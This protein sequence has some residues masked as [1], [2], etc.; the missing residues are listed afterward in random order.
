MKKFFM[1]LL[2]LLVIAVIGAGVFLAT[3]DADQYRP[4]ILGLIEKAIQK[5]VRLEKITL[6]WK[7]GMALELQGFAILKSNQ[8]Q[9]KLVEVQ[10]AKAVLKLVPL[11][12]KRIQVAAIHL[13]HPVIRLVKNPDGTFEGWEPEPAPSGET[14]EKADSGPE[15]AALLS[16]LVNEIRVQDGELFFKDRS[17]K[18]SMELDLRKIDVMVSDVELNRPINFQVNAAVLSKEQNLEVKGK[19][20]LA[21]QTRSGTVSGLRVE[22]Q[23]A[24][25]DFQE[26]IRLSPDLKTSGIVFPLGGTLTAESDSLK[27]DNEK[28]INNGVKILLQRGKIHFETLRKPIENISLGAW[29]TNEMIEIQQFSA[30]VAAG[31]VEGQGAV[32]LADSKNPRTDFD[33]KAD[34]ISIEELTPDYSS[35]PQVRGLLSAAMRGKLSGQTAEEMLRT[36]TAD[37]SVKLDQ[38]V[39][40]RVNV[41]REVFQKMSM[42]PG[43]VER[44]LTRLPKNYQ[45]KLKSEDTKLEMAQIPFSVQNGLLHLPRLEIATDSFVATGSGTYGLNEGSVTGKVL[46]AIEPDLSSAMTRSVEELQYLTNEKKEIQIPLVIQGLIPKVVVMPDVS[47]VASKMAAQKAREV[48]G[49]YLEKALAGK[50][51]APQNQPVSADAGSGESAVAKPS[52]GGRGLLEAL[53]QQGIRESGSGQ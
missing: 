23:L 16:L 10:S 5:P 33:V 48:L 8:S 13:V 39:I 50:N 52:S 36:L 14:Q 46:L 20:T 32:N 18:E 40:A 31:K 27:I 37:G 19:L 30:S 1:I 47:H 34:K 9:E 12:S 15:P 6:G 21:P 25:I 24:P 11:L 53:L 29:M 7:S 51:N 44:L 4:Q 26:V 3:F 49:G 45:E 22:L 2:I 43:L 28:L 17:G 38:A 35:G 41:L 42:I